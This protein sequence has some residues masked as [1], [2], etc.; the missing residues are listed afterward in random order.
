VGKDQESHVELTREIARRFNFLYGEVFPEPQA[1]IGEVPSLMGTDGK[2]KM[3]KSVGNAIFLADDAKTVEQKVR[4][5]YTDPTRIRADI[6]QIPRAI[7]S[8]QYHD[9]FNP[10]KAQVED[11]KTRYRAGKVG[12]VEV[13]KKL[14]LALN[15]F[16]IRSA[17]AARTT[18]RARK[19]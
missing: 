1:L 3:S 19:S 12:D 8:F 14:A 5:M 9:A 15:A 18:R 2:A 10:D 16:S 7:L 6:P 4:A 11:L 17:N 13:K